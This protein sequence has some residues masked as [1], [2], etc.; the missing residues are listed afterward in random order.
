VDP[1]RVR[2]TNVKVDGYVERIFVNFLGQAVKKGE[3]LFTLYSPTLLV[4]QNEYVMALHNKSATGLDSTLLAAARRK[5]ELWDV[6]AETIDALE[7]TGPTKT[8][9]FVSPT[10]GVVTGKDIVEGS[11]LEPGSTPYE[12][13]DLSVVWVMV[14]AYGSDLARVRLGME[15]TLSL[16]AYPGRLFSGRV[17]FIDPLLDPNTRTVKVHLHFANPTGELKPALYGDVVMRAETHVGLNIPLDAVIHSGT[18]SVVFVAEEQGKFRPVEVRLGERS[19]D[20]I[21][22]LSGL[23][24]GQAVVTRANFLVDSESQLRSSLADLVGR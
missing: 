13:T 24:E 1:T 11:Y 17:K 2:K 18:R 3:P 5:L 16:P 8:L 6:P 21:E 10:S 22:V 19:A 14:D 23:V 15:A 12:I 9:T 20:Q 7:R 4:T